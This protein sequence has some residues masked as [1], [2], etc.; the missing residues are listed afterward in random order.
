M[1]ENHELYSHKNEKVMGKFKLETPKIVKF[2]EFVPLRIKMYAFKGGIDSKNKIKG[3]LKSYSKNS[4]FEEYKKCSDGEK[5][6]KRI[7]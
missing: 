5:Y 2:Y 3:I 4:K 1:N 6:Q 7:R